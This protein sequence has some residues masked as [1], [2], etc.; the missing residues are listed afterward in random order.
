MSIESTIGPEAHYAAT[1]AEGRFL[2]QRCRECSAHVFYPRVFCIHCGGDALDWVEPTG[3][4]TVYSTTVVRLDRSNPHNVALVDLDEGVRVMSRVT[5]VSP[6]DV[7]I[8]MRVKAQ[9]ERSDGGS[10]LT[11]SPS[12]EDA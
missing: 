1:L 12:P 2:I 4:G 10:L 7:R 6:G 3:F 9:V 8:G 11:F 5:G